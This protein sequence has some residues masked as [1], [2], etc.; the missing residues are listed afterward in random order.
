[1]F[2]P[3][4]RI[5]QW[6]KGGL[7]SSLLFTMKIVQKSII[8]DEFNRILIV[9]RAKDDER[10]PNH[11]DTPGGGLNPGEDPIDGI[12]REIAEETTL[13]AAQTKKNTSLF[14]DLRNAGELTHEFI[15]YD[16]V[17]KPGNITLSS[18]H[19]GYQW[20]TEE[21]ILSLELVEPYLRDFA[22]KQKD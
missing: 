19:D 5:R 17:V 21:E 4:V 7:C 22:K 1:M 3:L 10:F 12:K 13:I 16:V 14:Y 9:K 15:V 11:W 6:T 8:R 18:E 20:A 2:P